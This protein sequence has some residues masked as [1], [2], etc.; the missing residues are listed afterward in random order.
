VLFDSPSF[1]LTLRLLKAVGI[2]FLC[3]VWG[4]MTDYWLD[5]LF[6]FRE[7]VKELRLFFSK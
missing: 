6:K 7:K 5:R 2:L 1:Y 4:K 3:S